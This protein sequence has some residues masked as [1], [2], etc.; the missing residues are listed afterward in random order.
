MSNC[1]SF[2][3]LLLLLLLLLL[4]SSSLITNPTLVIM[5]N[6]QVENDQMNT[7]KL[8][9]QLQPKKMSESE[10]GKKR[11]RSIFLSPDSPT[12]EQPI[13]S[14]LISSQA[15]EAG[16]SSP[17]CV[18]MKSDVSMVVPI[19]FGNK[20]QSSQVSEAGS[21]SPSCVSMK[22]DVSMV[23]PISFG[24]KAQSKRTEEPSKKKLREDP[25][26][27]RATEEDAGRSRFWKA[28]EILK[29]AMQRKFTLTREGLGDQEN[30][31]NSI[32][33]T[34]FITTAESEGP[35]EERSFRHTKRPQ[36]PEQSIDLCDI[37]KSLPGQEKPVRTV[38]TKGVAGIGKSFS[39]QKFILDWAKDRENQDVDFVFNL[40]FRELN[41][42]T[43]NR[44]LDKLLADFHPAV[45]GLIDSDDFVR[46][47]V[48]VILDGLD[49]GRL[50]LDFK[51]RQVT[52]VSEETSVGNLLENLIKGNLLPNANLWITSRPAAA[53]Q[54]PAEFVDVVTEIRGFSDS[55]KEEYFRTWFRQDEGVAEEIISRMRS[56]QSLDIMCQIPIF[57]WITAVLF[58]E[59]FGGVEKAET[60]QTLTEMMAH[61]L[62]T[63]KEI[64]RRKYDQKTNKE[65]LLKLGKLAFVQLQKNKLIFY[66]EDLKECGIDIP[67]AT[68][69]SGFCT[70]ILREERVFSKKKVFF[71]V[72][73]TI[74]EFFAALFVFDRFTNK[75]TKELDN[76]L[77]LEDK[78]HTLLDLLKMTV[79]KVLEDKN[80]HLDFFLRFLLG[81]MV[82]A[83]R[84]VLQ[85]LLT[86]PDSTQDTEKKILTW[87][88]TIRRKTLSPDSCINLFQNMVEMQDNKVKDEIQEYLKSNSSETLLTPLHCSALAY[89]LQISKNDLDVLDLKRY[90]T[91]EQGRRRLIPAVRS[92]RK[93][94]LADCKV[95]EEWIKHLAFGLKFPYL[96]L[97]DLDLS[98]NDLKDSGVKLLCDGLSSQCCRLETLRLS[99]CQIT[100]VG[101]DSLASAL[102]SKT[103]QL[104]ELDL[105]Y[106]HPGESGEKLLSELKKDPQNKL[107]V[108]NLDH[109]GGNRMKPGFKKYA[110]ELTLD[111]NTAH[112]ELLLSEG[113]RKVTCVEDEQPYPPHPDRFDGCQ[114]VLC[115]QGLQGRCY[116][117]AE[118]TE[119]FS[120]G[121]T[122]R[123]IS[124]KGDVNDC[125]L[126]RNDK[127]W[128]MT[129]C[130]GGS[131]VLHD[132]QSF[133]VSSLFSRSSRVGVYLDRPAGTLSFY[134]ASSDSRTLL[135]TF[136]AEFKEP[137]YAAV[138]LRTHSSASFCQLT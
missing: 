19:S 105:S 121:M 96:P 60:P 78:E 125:R 10:K 92:S 32:Y 45:Q 97:R 127:S 136:S 126:G 90:N 39:V 50:R 68:I 12:P 131:F 63:Q 65:F 95:N 116:F 6:K 42:S 29:K 34:L 62:I 83:N 107:V 75:N 30:P 123:S 64:R 54:I 22:S 111:P 87:L 9:F 11:R 110:C 122:Y 41:L 66:E 5:N 43:D 18:S 130:D 71:F 114:Q 118:A 115:E 108:L 44:S 58:K 21:S 20:A 88:K 24:N 38:L 47:K 94:I 14:E 103:S 15:S 113:N 49:E 16:S 134:R 85:G 36:S 76:F 37:L 57:C 89:M 137:L 70:T 79:E 72:H 48:I 1:G 102:R 117:E 73:L 106:N 28:K 135:R 86:P 133:C 51:T 138:E 128:C 80:G 109:G 33:T 2:R 3:R 25:D 67:E 101:C 52:S 8:K 129:C 59:M 93:A 112:K 69:Y 91:S 55:Q 35:H 98:N 53:N 120:I 7:F 132:N 61:L 81:L 13:S 104:K 77:N 17:S 31:M 100:E 119:P 99:G 26:H 74:Q 40:A 84:S 82:E 46:A 4:L 27:Q 23:V 124:R 56:S